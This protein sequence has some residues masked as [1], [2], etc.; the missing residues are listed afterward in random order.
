MTQYRPTRIT[1]LFA[2]RSKRIPE[3]IFEDVSVKVGNSI[4]P[5][6][7]VVLDYE[8]ESKDPLILERAFLATA[9]ARFDV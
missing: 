1:L 4:I 3:G 2:D 9:G 6:D 5:A 8:K 7:F